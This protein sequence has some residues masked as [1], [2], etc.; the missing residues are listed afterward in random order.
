LKDSIVINDE[1][2]DS[3]IAELNDLLEGVDNNNRKLSEDIKPCVYQ[4]D[5][6]NINKNLHKNKTIN[7]NNMNYNNHEIDEA[8][9][10]K[11]KL[12]GINLRGI[13]KSKMFVS[14][15]ETV[16]RVFLSTNNMNSV[17][18]PLKEI[19]GLGKI[20]GNN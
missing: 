14:N 5:I 4:K 15:S 10:N 12:G 19:K 3:L 11:L 2:N 16:N 9:S 6:N 8:I 17:K 7:I 18:V 20:T 1:H 13:K